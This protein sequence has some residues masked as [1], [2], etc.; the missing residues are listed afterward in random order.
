MYHSSNVSKTIFSLLVSYKDFLLE[1]HLSRTYWHKF[2]DYS[3]V[4]VADR[5]E[6][7]RECMISISPTSDFRRSKNSLLFNDRRHR[8]SCTILAYLWIIRTKSKWNQIHKFYQSCLIFAGKYARLLDREL[9]KRKQLMFSLRCFRA[10]QTSLS[11]SEKYASTQHCM[12]CWESKIP[13]N[14]N[15]L[16]LK[17]QLS[18]L[19]PNYQL[20]S[21]GTSSLVIVS[22]SLHNQF[23]AQI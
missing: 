19:S 22:D 23:A 14:M 8:F 11:E 18:D 5:C 20:Y 17:R 13:K 2:Q 15:H 12:T 4:L 6:Y 1:A 16:R 7:S 3:R 21:S 9:W 10:T